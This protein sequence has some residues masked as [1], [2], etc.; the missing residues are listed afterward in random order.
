[1]A[2]L[3]GNGGGLCDL[4]VKVSDR[5]SCG[6]KCGV[7]ERV[8]RSRSRSSLMF[9]RAEGRSSVAARVIPDQSPDIG[10]SLRNSGEADSGVKAPTP[11]LAE[12]NP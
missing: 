10:R 12:S 2:S 3:V 4:S 1:M 8:C 5:A 9:V 6:K 11:L 7:K